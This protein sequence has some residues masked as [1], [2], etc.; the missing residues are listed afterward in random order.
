VLK[1]HAYATQSTNPMP[2]GRWAA[3]PVAE[4]TKHLGDWSQAT[5]A[6]GGSAS[7]APVRPGHRSCVASAAKVTGGKSRPLLEHGSVV[8]VGVV[9]GEVQP[10]G[11]HRIVGSAYL[12]RLGRIGGA[13]DDRGSPRKFMAR[14]FGMP[15]RTTAAT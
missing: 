4:G 14:T 11:A 5:G 15:K 9:R 6:A 7:E 13:N 8:C 12:D 3:V 10:V 1:V 2:P